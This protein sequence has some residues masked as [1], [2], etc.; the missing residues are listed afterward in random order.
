MFPIDVKKGKYN[1]EMLARFNELTSKTAF[2]QDLIDVLPEIVP[3]GEI[4]GTLTEEGALLLDPTGTL[5]SGI[6][7]CPP[8]GDA[9]TGMVATNSIAVRTGNVSAGTSIFAM[10]VL[11]N[12]L[13]RVYRQID[14]VTTPTGNP[15]AMVHCN[16]C[17]TEL[18]CWVRFFDNTLKTFG[19]DIPKSE[20]YDKLY[21]AAL[22]GEPDCGGIVS[23]N[24]HSG[25]HVTGF[26]SGKPLVMRDPS[27]VLN[28][29]NFMRNLVYSCMATLKIGMDILISEEKISLD[30]IYAHGGLFKSPAATQ[31]FLAAALGVPVALMESAGEGG[32]WGIALLASY[33]VRKEDS[34]TLEEY[35]E[36]RVFSGKTGNA[37]SPVEADIN[38]FNAY[39]ERYKNGLSVESAATNIK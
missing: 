13:A 32:A 31:R 10:A 30:K 26:T 8:E 7:F 15:V 9:Q 34:E 25:E 5:K 24:Y 12:D 20:L 2:G 14:I 22:S 29:A 4:A 11:E 3:V 6:P 33:L 39:I 27:S 35:L 23:Y 1:E 16:N 28:V 37:V 36:N 17:S 19:V 38:G 18:D 21:D